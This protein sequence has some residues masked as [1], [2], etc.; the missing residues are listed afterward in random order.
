MPPAGGS[1]DWWVACVR[2]G[3]GALPVGLSPR[4]SSFPPG[5][6]AP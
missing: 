6:G 2:A 4:P 1:A 5:Y 3:L